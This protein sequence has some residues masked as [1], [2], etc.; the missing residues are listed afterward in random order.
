MSLDLDTFL[1]LPRVSGLALAPDGSRLVTGVATVAADGKRFASS[2]WELDPEGEHPP[3][4]LT[5]SRPGES[6]P[7][8]LPDGDLLFTSA[9]PDPGAT[10][11]EDGAEPPSALW[12][13]PAD[14]GEAQLLAAPPAGLTGLAVARDRPT[15]VLA[16]PAHPDAADLEADAEREQARKDAGVTARLYE[17]YPI[18]FW[19]RWYGPRQ[20]RL[21]AGEVDDEAAIEPLGDLTRDPRDGLEQAEFDLTPDGSTVVTSW[22]RAVE[23]PRQLTFDLVAIA[24]G[25]GAQ[26]LLASGDE[27]M[28]TAPACSPDGR[29]VVCVREARDTPQAPG[30]HTLWLVDLETGEGRDL[31]PGF[32]RWPEHPVWARD[33]SAMLFT[34]DDGGHV[35]PYSVEL[36]TG[37]VSRLASEGAFSDL[38]PSGDGRIY[39]LRSAVDTPPRVVALDR[40][41]THQTP[42]ELPSPGAEFA[43]PG[44]VERLSTRAEDGSEVSGWLVLPHEIDSAAPLAVLVHG[45]PLNS[46]AGW[47]WRWNPHLLAARGWAV[48]LPD[49]ALSTGYGLDFIARGW[50]RWGAEPYT[51]IMALVDAAVARD[52]IDEARTA[53]LGGSFG[54]YMANWIAGHTDRFDA[55]VTHAS[56][57]ELTGFHG[58]TDAGVW[59]ERQFGDP[60][61]EPERY[62]EHS[63]HRH[64]GAITTPML[65]THGERDMRVPMGE[66]L[67]LWT[68]LRRHGVG[69]RF[70]AFDDEH[71]WIEKPQNARL[72]YATVFAFLDHHVLGEPWRRPD[73][74]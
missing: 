20:R 51:D 18:R 40:S 59:W 15:V 5:R 55:I 25:S 38:C 24:T 26:R 58:T 71:H 37:A 3:R 10:D 56:L 17:R 60:Y 45:G 31:L 28:L 63:P 35:L 69:G 39:A 21:W 4:R 33:G 48:L 43:L 72:W 65:V 53:A 1:A 67:R 27:G 74:L 22:W 46:W 54:G 47:H 13:L 7:A 36:A 41:R 42:V 14:G 66:S 19:D 52:D 12:R 32:D 73:L 11:T 34:A 6:A 44:Q 49:P 29:S 16:V 50:G 70:L 62:V 8:F 23:D 9:R 68:D 61:A 64:V 30:D 2:L 57:W